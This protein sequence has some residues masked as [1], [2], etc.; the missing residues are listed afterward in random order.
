MKV[1]LNLKIES[2]VHIGSGDSY[3]EMDFILEENAVKIIDYEK[4]LSILEFDEERFEKL[5]ELAKAG[6]VKNKIKEVLSIDTIPYFRIIDFRGTPP[7]RSLKIQKHIQSFGRAYI[8]GSSIKGFVR[9]ALL[10]KYLRDNPEILRNEFEALKEEISRKKQKKG[11]IDK[12]I[13]AKNLERKIFGS[14]PK[15]D[16]LRFLRVTDSSFAQKTA[17]YEVKVIGNPQNIPLYLECI[18]PGEILKCKAEIEEKF[19][20]TDGSIG[21]LKL[22]DVLE[23]LRD[24][25]RDIIKSEKSYRYPERTLNFYLELERKE[26]LLRLGHSTGYYSKTIGFLLKDLEN[27][28]EFRRNLELGKN[29][30]TKRF[31]A[32]FPKTR[33]LTFQDIPLGWISFEVKR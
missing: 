8:P 20:E 9:T 15:K 23:V 3:I 27:F 4:L 31:V 29:P 25:T 33:R 26:N 1:E 10:Y 22:E 11:R 6:E 12:R 14:D 17:I 16:A 19:A 30:H 21:K 24:F 2:P 28:D 13:I 18:P 7:K 32:K 5:L